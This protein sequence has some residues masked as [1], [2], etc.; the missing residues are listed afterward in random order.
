MPKKERN[1]KQTPYITFRARV[2]N[3]VDELGEVS[4]FGTFSKVFLAV[5][6]LRMR[7]VLDTDSLFP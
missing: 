1:R 4:S 7:L 6:E 3:V 2:L 5:Q